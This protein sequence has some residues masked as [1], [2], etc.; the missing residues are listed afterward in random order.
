MSRT[1]WRVPAALLAASAAACGTLHGAGTGPP[2]LGPEDAVGIV[3][4]R[5]ARA[6]GGEASREAEN[7]R[8]K[9]R[10]F[11]GCVAEG[12][13]DAAPRARVLEPDDTWP[14]LF[15]GTPYEAAPRGWDALLEALER[16]PP[17][18][19]SG[20]PPVRYLVV[21]DVETREEAAATDVGMGGDGG[22]GGGILVVAADTRWDRSTRIEASV[23][24]LATVEECGH[25]SASSRGNEGWI[26]GCGVCVIP[27][28]V[29]PFPIPPV[30][31]TVMTES[32][33]CAD[34]GKRLG[35]GFA[36]AA[37]P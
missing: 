36:G 24:D 7:L 34:I 8:G 27:P 21:L 19:P 37:E 22:G 9:E 23:L 25:L 26:Y 33:T 3:L 10:F 12:I 6:K 14:L 35:E 5:Y 13:R 30:P 11:G 28:C 15:P 29:I 16:S 18:G 1:W 17:C 4:T 20:V 31:R 32:S 2:A